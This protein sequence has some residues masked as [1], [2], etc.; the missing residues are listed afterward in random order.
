MSRRSESALPWRALGGLA[1]GAA[2]AACLVLAGKSPWVG[3]P[4]AAAP[5]QRTAPP[6]RAETFDHLRAQASLGDVEASGELVAL[7]M[8]RFEREGERDDL[9]EAMQ[10]LARDWDQ[11][12]FVRSH[13]LD[14][15]LERHC[16]DKV[17][18][19]HWLCSGGD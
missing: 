19:W 2:L 5:V 15:L 3:A 10:W 17:L 6:P 13:L 11:P 7:L 14:R 18:R 9:H 4:V 12:A 1:C 16:G 8:A